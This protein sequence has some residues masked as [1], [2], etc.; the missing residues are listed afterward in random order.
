MMS[1]RLRV[2]GPKLEGSTSRHRTDIFKLCSGDIPTS[3]TLI[4]CKHVFVCGK[5]KTNP[6]S[7]CYPHTPPCLIDAGSE[8][9]E[10]EKQ[11]ILASHL[12]SLHTATIP[13]QPIKRCILVSSR[14]TR[15]TSWRHSHI[16]IFIQQPC[17]LGTKP[18][19]EIKTA[20]KI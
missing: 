12:F 4:P 9:S 16:P 20:F 5:S 10:D 17:M 7:H 15:P 18:E 13:A 2:P 1:L 19:Y 11:W 14:T 3:P 8:I 6:S